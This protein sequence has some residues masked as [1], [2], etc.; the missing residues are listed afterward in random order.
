MSDTLL[1]S[2]VQRWEPS[3]RRFVVAVLAVLFGVILSRLI[4]V[5]VEPG[6][7]V[8]QTAPLPRYNLSEA[9]Q[10]RVNADT[11]LLTQMNP[12]ALG[13]QADELLI[14]EAPETALNLELKASRWSSFDT[15]ASATILTPDNQTRVYQP[16]DEIIS[17]VTLEKVLRN[18][19]VLLRRNGVIES[20]RKSG[21]DEELSVLE[22]DGQRTTSNS[23]TENAPRSVQVADGQALY[24]SLQISPV[25][26]DGNI[27]GYRLNPRDDGQL[28]RAAGLQ[29]GDVLIALDGDGIGDI[30]PEDLADRIVSGTSVSLTVERQGKTEVV[31]LALGR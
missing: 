19:E 6:G 3:F 28:M 17:G 8:S 23:A 24:L 4:W 31:E 11:N 5:L 25:N 13:D 9:N 16:G 22:I 30:E 27:V 29:P 26:E 21:R 2:L 20:L 10:V 1:Q 15:F 7:A 14:D 18:D 12:F